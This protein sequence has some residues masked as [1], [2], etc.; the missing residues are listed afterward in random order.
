V[1][2]IVLDALGI[3]ERR[4]AHVGHDA[5]AAK[6]DRE[7]PDARAQEPVLV[8]LGSDQLHQLAVGHQLVRLQEPIGRLHPRQHMDAHRACPVGSDTHRFGDT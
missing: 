4:G 8:E 1:G 6:P 7:Q 3:G 5:D 2:D